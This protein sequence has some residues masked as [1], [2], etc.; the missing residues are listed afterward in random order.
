MGITVAQH[1]IWSWYYFILTAEE[2]FVAGWGR[3]SLPLST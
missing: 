2:T 3:M 1:T